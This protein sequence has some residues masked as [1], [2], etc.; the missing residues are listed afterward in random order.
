MSRTRD[1]II[2]A[3]TLA[4]GRASYPATVAELNPV[5][6]RHVE[7]IAIRE[8]VGQGM[9]LRDARAHAAD[10]NEPAMARALHALRDREAAQ[11]AH[12]ASQAEA[13]AL[14]AS[15]TGHTPP[16]HVAALADEFAAATKS[17]MEPSS[18]DR[19]RAARTAQR[20]TV[21]PVDRS[22]V[23]DVMRAVYGEWYAA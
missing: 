18:A 12:A 4:S 9:H 14:V 20:A 15:V 7:H 1:D 21:D 3:A 5:Q 13:T 19:F 10:N 8:L 17:A 22:T 2:A 23:D 11:R 16:S 6:R